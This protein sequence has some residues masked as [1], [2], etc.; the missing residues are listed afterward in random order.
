[1]VAHT[2]ARAAI[3]WASHRFIMYVPPCIS[4][5]INNEMAWVG[6]VQKKNYFDQNFADLKGFNT[7]HNDI[8]TLKNKKD[9]EVEWQENYA[10]E[11]ENC[12]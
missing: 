7:Y 10:Q 2:L 5:L 9:D 3:S 4:S 1:M 11:K 12:Q 6:C 8:A